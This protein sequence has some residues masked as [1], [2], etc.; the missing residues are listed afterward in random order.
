[1][2]HNHVFISFEG[3]KVQFLIEKCTKRITKID[4]ALGLKKN[5]RF[6]WRKYQLIRI[7]Y[8]LL[9]KEI[10]HLDQIQR[11]LINRKNATQFNIKEAKTHH[12]C[13]LRVSFSRRLL[14]A[15]SLELEAKESRIEYLGLESSPPRNFLSFLLKQ[16]RS[17]L[18][19]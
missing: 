12:N 3:Q 15:L 17:L 10:L 13:R 2:L 11:K 7:V 6:Q 1:M 16:K 8:L 4:M 5:C 14:L 19:I 9:M 18:C